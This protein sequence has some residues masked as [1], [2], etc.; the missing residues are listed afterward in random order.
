MYNMTNMFNML[1]RSNMLAIGTPDFTE[2]ERTALCVF[3]VNNPVKK[4]EAELFLSTC[5]DED[6]VFTCL[7]NVLQLAN[8]SKKHIRIVIGPVADD[9]GFQEFVEEL[10]PFY[11]LPSD[12]K[13][14]EL[15]VKGYN[16]CK[17][18]FPNLRPL[19]IKKSRWLSGNIIVD[20]LTQIIQEWNLNENVFTITTDNGSL[21]LAERLVAREKCLISFFTTPKQTERLIEAQKNMRNIQ[22]E[23]AIKQLMDI[24][25]PFAS[26]TKLLEGKPNIDFTYPTTVFDDVGI[27]DSDDDEVDDHPK[28]QKISTN[29]SR[30]CK[31]L[32]EKVKLALYTAINKPLLD[33]GIDVPMGFDI[34]SEIC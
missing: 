8:P 3:F 19:D 2:D 9:E 31:D 13:V 29:I 4:K 28:W 17:Q 6:E 15:S 18:V 7:K 30:D 26:A 20:C 12:K 5:N 22:Q 25:E 14:K 21:L 1:I 32:T 11:E 10:N 33:S 24:L 34:D 23:T 16:Y 27:E